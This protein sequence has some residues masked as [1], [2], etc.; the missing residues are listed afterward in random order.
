MIQIIST[1]FFIQ[2]QQS[3]KNR[4]HMKIRPNE[5]KARGQMKQNSGDLDTEVI[6]G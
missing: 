5:Q 2:C 4:E 6:R 1:A 3:I